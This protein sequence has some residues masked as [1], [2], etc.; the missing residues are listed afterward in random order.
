MMLVKISNALNKP[1]C[2]NLNSAAARQLS[3]LLFL[4]T[5]TRSEMKSCK[6]QG[7]IRAQWGVE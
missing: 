2:G 5:G 6:G 7:S 1:T 3:N 4:Q